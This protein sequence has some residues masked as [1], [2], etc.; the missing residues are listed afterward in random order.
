MLTSYVR[1]RILWKNRFPQCALPNAKRS[2]RL[3]LRNLRPLGF[4]RRALTETD[5]YNVCKDRQIEI[6]WSD[7]KFS[8]YFTMLGRSIITLPK[9]LTGVNLRF[10]VWHEFAH[11][12]LGHSKCGGAFF[13]GLLKNNEELEADSVALI[14]LMPLASLDQPASEELLPFRGER[15][16]LYLR[17]GV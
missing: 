7:E 11:H 10:A 16:K 2:M 17:R 12:A 4:N 3:L 14:A 1:Y 15:E 9:R 13:Q 6:V 8:F 5:F